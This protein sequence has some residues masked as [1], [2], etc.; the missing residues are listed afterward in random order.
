MLFSF[1]TRAGSLQQYIL[2]TVH[3]I[4]FFLFSLPAGAGSPQQREPITVGPYYLFHP[5][6]FPWKKP[7]YPE[8]PKTFSRALTILFSNEDWVHTHLTKNQTRNFRGE[9]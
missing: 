3:I 9:R 1:V 8:K 5:V 4:L 2:I 6:N 7:K